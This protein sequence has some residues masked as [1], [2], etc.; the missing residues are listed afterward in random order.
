[1]LTLAD[2]N[3]KKDE[4]SLMFIKRVMR[5]QN[6]SSSAGMDNMIKD[7]F[8]FSGQSNCRIAVIN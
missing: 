3:F 8:D 5:K 1:M 6:M 2:E 7:G 4:K